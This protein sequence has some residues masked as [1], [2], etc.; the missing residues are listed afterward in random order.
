MCYMMISSPLYYIIKIMIIIRSR[1]YSDP[2]QNPNQQRQ[3]NESHTGRNLAIGALGT[4]AT[5]GGLVAGKK[6]MLGG[7]IQKSINSAYA[8]VGK[9]VG[10]KA[11][12]QSGAKGYAE[13]QLRQNFKNETWKNK[14]G[15][16]G[17]NFKDLSQET[18][19]QLVNKQ[20]VK[21]ENAWKTAQDLKTDAAKK[22]ADDNLA[23]TNRQRNV[24]QNRVDSQRLNSFGNFY[25]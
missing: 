4:A 15:F 5:I 11:M 25:S 16:G 12:Q 21:N 1:Y 8:G 20:V 13:G 7:G 23:L 3:S 22:L 19:E 17:Q 9:A 18:R 14:H 6:G 24:L 2:N 10:S